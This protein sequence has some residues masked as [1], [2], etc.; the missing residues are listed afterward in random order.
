MSIVVQLFTMII[1]NINYYNN[2]LLIINLHNS[3]G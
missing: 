2:V 3:P 1:I